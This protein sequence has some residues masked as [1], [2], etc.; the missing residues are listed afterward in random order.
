MVGWP[1]LNVDVW[2]ESHHAIRFPVE[3]FYWSNGISK[4]IPV[5]GK[6]ADRLNRI[7]LEDQSELVQRVYAAYGRTIIAFAVARFSE[8]RIQTSIVSSPRDI[9]DGDPT[10]VSVNPIFYAAVHRQNPSHWMQVFVHNKTGIRLYQY[11]G[12][13]NFK[14]PDNPTENFITDT[15]D[16][17]TCCP[18]D[19]TKVEPIA[20]AD[21][22]P[23][24]LKEK[25]M[26]QFLRR[27]LNTRG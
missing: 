12:S 7:Y 19:V 10:L 23:P 9:R 13:E 1:V 16:L 22:F 8:G 21:L 24:E 14:A 26:H 5:Y 11:S 3:G 18:A 2:D 17:F 20:K 27:E 4:L 15:L 25:L 6:P